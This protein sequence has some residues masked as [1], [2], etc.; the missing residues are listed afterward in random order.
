MESVDG[1]SMGWCGQIEAFSRAHLIQRANLENVFG[2][3]LGAWRR[4][5]RFAVQPRSA[6]IFVGI[7]RILGSA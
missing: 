5:S 6:N 3:T 4:L 1:V 2:S 7:K